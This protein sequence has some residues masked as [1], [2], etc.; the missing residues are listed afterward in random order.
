MQISV[1]LA[2]MTVA[3]WASPP[4]YRMNSETTSCDPHLPS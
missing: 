3:K 1:N 4:P 2:F